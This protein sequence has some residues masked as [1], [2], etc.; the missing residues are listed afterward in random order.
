MTDPRRLL[1]KAARHGIEQSAEHCG[2]RW[3]DAAEPTP[4]GLTAESIRTIREWAD[5]TGRR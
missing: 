4:S 3:V 1:G 5:F 2:D